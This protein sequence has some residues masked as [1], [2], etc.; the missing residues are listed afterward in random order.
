MPAPDELICTGLLLGV[1]GVT[2]EPT[3]VAVGLLHAFAT[4][5][6]VACVAGSRAPELTSALAG[7]VAG[8][9]G[10]LLF[11]IAWLALIMPFAATVIQ[12]GK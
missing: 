7:C 5:Q 11:E 12:A 3:A 2:G 8:F 10:A 1:A 4:L 6:L 9:A